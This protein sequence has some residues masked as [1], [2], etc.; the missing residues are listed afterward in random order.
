MTTV[1]LGLIG[2]GMVVF[3]HELGHFLAAR[4]VGV[5]VE[6]FSLGW[7]PK[8][9]GLVRGKTEYRIS[10]F[11]IGGFCRMKGEEAF[12]AAMERGDQDMPREPGSY[13]GAS[14]W[15][16]IVIALAGPLANLFFALL[17][18]TLVVSAGYDI[19]TFGNRIV[20][21]ADYPFPGEPVSSLPAERAGLKTGD[22]IVAIDGV[23]TELYSEIQE[24][25][26]RAPEKNLRFT[27]ERETGT[28]DL[29]VTP[30]LD[31]E[32]ATGRVGIY[33]WQETVIEGVA[34]GS[35]AYIAGLA[36]GDRVV[37]VDGNPVP[38]SIAFLRALSVKSQV[39]R[40]AYERDGSRKE[41]DLVL[42]P[43]KDGSPDSG[44]VFGTLTYHIKA[45]GFLDALSRGSA[46]TG[47]TISGTLQGLAALFRG[48]VN[49]MNA[50]SGPVRITYMVGVVA[51]E[52]FQEGVAKGISQLFNFL[53]LLSIGLFI[54]NLLPIP[55]LDGG[56]ILLFIVEGIRGKPLKLKTIYRYQVIG[57]AVVIALFLLTGIAD[58]TFF[59]GR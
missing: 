39:L 46:E 42:T 59:S 43:G 2:L 38:H 45:R 55:L 26:A 28:L 7:G 25:V 24:I 6:A 50:V 31:R 44:I 5:E 27:V 41:T 37:S 4:L 35:S 54:M 12:K 22:R 53:S 40:I 57:I 11:P 52:G 18:S 58:A 3:V 30:D 33:P 9:F 8:L 56:Q 13:F 1:I 15:R 10:V 32:T 49:I 48:N 14:P 23:R 36:E 20:L 19:R 21:A 51:R 17:V 16:R 34:A 47:K 29:T